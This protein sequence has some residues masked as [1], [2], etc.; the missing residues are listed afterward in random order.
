MQKS[1]QRTPPHMQAVVIGAGFGGLSTALSMARR[2]VRVVVFERLNYPGGC[3]STFE[4]GGYF[5]ESGATLFSGFGENQLFKQWKDE[6]NLPVDLNWIDPVVEL[7]APGLNLPISRDRQKFIDDLCRLPNAPV[8]KLREFFAFQK[9]VA[10]LLWT[11]LGTPAL[12]PP[13]SP[14]TVLK[15]IPLLIG[16]RR[17]IPWLGKPLITV[18]DAFGLSDF[19]PLRIMLDAVS[20]ITVQAPAHEAEA[21]IALATADYFFRGTCHI[22]GGIGELAHAIAESIENHGGQ[23]CYKTGVKQIEKSGTGWLVHTTRGSTQCST[24]IANLLPQAMGRLS[25]DLTLQS[26]LEPIN[27]RVREGWGAAMLYRAIR[28]NADL[29]PDP[30][31]IQ[32]VGNP[33][34]PFSAGNHLFASI[35][36]RN[37]IGRSP[38]GSRVITVSTH[39]PIAKY[40]ELESQACADYIDSIHQTMRDNLAHLAP[41]LSTEV[42]YELTGSPRTFERFTG[43]PEG[44]VGGIPK[45]AGLHNYRN[46][47]PL[48]P[49]PG[50]FLVGDSVFPGQS[51]LAA[52][53][54]GVKAAQVAYSH[55]ESLNFALNA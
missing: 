24:V 15:N 40:R 1:R 33:E 54:G 35:S 29:P 36:G 47:G 10:D 39:V 18:L 22:N 21:L 27:S 32:I 6:L 28:D 4:R 51:T 38:P 41:D 48:Q 49:L 12:L 46:L 52:S 13:F 3:A 17:L 20:Q 2:G 8:E 34:L 30:H 5:F 31:H 26:K 45:R 55:N 50:L 42:L 7:R 19:K 11:I 44:L 23:V 14:T 25:N 37:E 43:R 53:L 16:G 9:E